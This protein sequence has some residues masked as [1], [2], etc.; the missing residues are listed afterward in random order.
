MWSWFD[1]IRPLNCALSAF[2]VIIGAFLVFPMLTPTVLLAAFVVFLLTG[3]GNTVNDIMDISS[4][5]INHPQRPLPSGR[6]SKRN[7]TIFTAGLFVSGVLLSL[8]LNNVLCFA[9]AVLN[10]FLLIVYSKH[11]Q[12]KVI[13]GNVTV[14]YLGS[15]AFLFGGAAAG[16][17]SLSLLLMA[18]AGLATFA[19]EIVKDLEDLEG[20]R[21]SFIKKMA[22]RVKESFGDRFRVS[23]SGIKLRYKTIYAILFASFSIWL[24]VVA[25]VIPYI[26][27]LLSEA[28]IFLL[29]PTDAVL[30]LSSIIL[31][32]KRNYRLVSKLLKA[33]MYLGMAAF[34]LGAIL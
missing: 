28:Y 34:L 1:I 6:V 5:R 14:A 26:W 13:L 12:N 23:K 18:L 11:L 33:G 8:L 25:S 31:I 32:R 2:G 22:F 19:R 27:G 10:T 24:A 21:H 9:I 16:D 15:S 3:A 4:D 30:V 7:A 17:V 29:V 20:D